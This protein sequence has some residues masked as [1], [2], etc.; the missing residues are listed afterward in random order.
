MTWDRVALFINDILGALL[1]VRLL[2]LRLH[3]VYSVF[4]LFIL[5]DLGGSSVLFLSLL[6]PDDLDYRIV[7]LCCA[8][9]SWIAILWMVY[10]LLGAML[11][12]LP[13]VLTFSRKLLNVTFLCAIIIAVITAKPDLNAAQVSASAPFLHTAV[14]V[15]FVLDR[16]IATTALTVLLCILGFVVWFPV[17]MP[18]NLVLFSFGF[19]TYFGSRTVL[20]LIHDFLGAKTP[21]LLSVIDTCLLSLC[22][23]YWIVTIMPEGETIPIRIGHGWEVNQQKLLIDRLETMNSTLLRDARRL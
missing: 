22:F 7:W 10:A 2:R 19:I 23:V 9:M 8:A 5:L 12:T 21:P 13:G 3:R 17:Q 4:S 14:N 15:G 1:I 6:Y 18:K 11:A 16:V 20:L